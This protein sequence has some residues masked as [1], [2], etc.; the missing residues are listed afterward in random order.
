MGCVAFKGGEAITILAMKLRNGNSVSYL[1][2]V[3]GCKR[4]S[5]LPSATHADTHIHTK[6]SGMTWQSFQTL[7]P[8]PPPGIYTQIMIVFFFSFPWIQLVIVALH[9][10]LNFFLNASI[11]NICSC[12]ET[13]HWLQLH[14]LI[15]LCWCRYFWW[16]K[17]DS[18]IF[19]QRPYDYMF[20]CV[21]CSYLP[22][23]WELDQ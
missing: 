2:Q 8:M 15:S 21:K 13:S 6:E 19:K 7:S 10:A 1:S 23:M 20:R 22:K 16:S 5:V 3:S 11:I 12:C 4:F 14:N 17:G 9:Y 18:G